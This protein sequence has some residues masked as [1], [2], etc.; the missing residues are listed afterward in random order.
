[1]ILSSA[2]AV[3]ERWFKFDKNI[4][5]ANCGPVEEKHEI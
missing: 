3:S 5:F 2:S 1:M 4:D